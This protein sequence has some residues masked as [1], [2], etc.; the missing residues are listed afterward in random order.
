MKDKCIGKKGRKLKEGNKGWKGK[1]KRCL[2]IILL[3][4]LFTKN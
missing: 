1:E 2:K 4:L 3:I